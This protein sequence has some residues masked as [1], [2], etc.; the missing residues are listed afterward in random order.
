MTRAPE[1]T[2]AP[3]TRPEMRP[4]R[5]ARRAT[6]RR[7][8][9][10]RGRTPPSPPILLLA[11][12]AR[13]DRPIRVR[14]RTPARARTRARSRTPG[15]PPTPGRRRMT[16]G[17]SSTL[18]PTRRPTAGARRTPA[19]PTLGDAS[20]TTPVDAG[21]VVVDSGV[22]CGTTTC[23]PNGEHPVCCA[24]GGETCIAAGATCGGITLGCDGPGNCSAGSL[25]CFSY[26]TISSTCTPVDSGV[27]PGTGVQLCEKSAD[28]PGGDVCDVFGSC[29]PSG[30]R[31]GPMQAS[32][33]ATAAET[34]P[35]PG[36]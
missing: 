10:T 36:R 14:S 11:T 15:P 25:C 3:T 21:H 26:G 7:P 32:L 1:T 17:P 23:D 35:I 34:R 33:S 9:S 12:T 2:A 19:S 22:P 16:P 28:C 6:A 31:P 8:A 18:A 13:P 5:T 27:C 24:A 4:A 20:T 29:V 30:R